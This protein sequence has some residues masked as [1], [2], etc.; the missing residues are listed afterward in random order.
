MP[1]I[2]LNLLYIRREWG[3][4]FTN[5]HFKVFV[6]PIQMSSF[7]FLKQ[8]ESD[9]TLRLLEMNNNAVIRDIVFID[10]ITWDTD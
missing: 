2:A 3:A 8:E 9:F 6:A 7:Y 10:C 5:M 1:G 4:H